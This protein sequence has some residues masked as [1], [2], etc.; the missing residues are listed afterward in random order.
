MPVKLKTKSDVDDVMAISKA[1]YEAGRKNFTE[2]YYRAG[3]DNKFGGQDLEIPWQ[4]LSDA[5]QAYQRDNPSVEVGLR[6]VYCFEP[7]TG[8]LKLRMQLCKMEESEEIANT[9]ILVD[10]VCAWYK[11]KNSNLV[12]C[13]D[14]NLVSKNYFT[15]FYYCATPPCDG[16]NAQL[17]ADGASDQ[18]YAR[19]ITFPWT[20]EVQQLYLDNNSPENATICFGAT[21]YVHANSGDAKIAFPHGLVLYLKD[22][23]GHPLL[24]NDKDSVAIFHN[25]GADFGTLC[26]TKCKV[27]IVPVPI[28]QQASI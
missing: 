6:I 7:E 18:L 12:P 19:T 21:S 24:D 16:K 22:A 9:Y 28:T 17:L 20:L 26:P 14:H 23:D 11:I 4:Q 13:K 15:N 2:H 10:D 25:K 1:E 5:V 27:Y 3:C 8:N